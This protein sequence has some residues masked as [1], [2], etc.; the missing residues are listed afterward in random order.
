MSYTQQIWQAV[1]IYT[2]KDRL[3]RLSVKEKNSKQE[4]HYLNRIQNQ[5]QYDLSSLS[6][7]HDNADRSTSKRTA[8][9]RWRWT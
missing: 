7:I 6:L 1:R 5:E 2:Y 8:Q 4:K 9:D 3:P